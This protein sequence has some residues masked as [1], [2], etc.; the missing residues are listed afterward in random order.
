LL[1]QAHLAGLENRLQGVR[2]K[3][4]RSSAGEGPW[5]GVE[6]GG[7]VR[8]LAGPVLSALL[9]TAAMSC[10]IVPIDLGLVSAA[11]PLSLAQTPLPFWYC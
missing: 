1:I 5:I 4:E 3:T 11:P 7:M 9:L 6:H 10:R 8:A 2:L